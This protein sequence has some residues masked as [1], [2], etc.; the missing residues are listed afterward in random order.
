MRQARDKTSLGLIY[1]ASFRL[2]ALLETTTLF[3]GKKM[4]SLEDKVY[5]ENKK[6]V[7][8]FHRK[9]RVIFCKDYFVLFKQVVQLTFAQVTMVYN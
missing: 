3:G 7:E 6:K 2:R 1:V 8:M 9:S 4:Y 5:A